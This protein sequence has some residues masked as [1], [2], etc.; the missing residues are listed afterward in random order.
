MSEPWVLCI[1]VP[2]AVPAQSTAVRPGLHGGFSARGR[3][4]MVPD[5]GRGWCT[6]ATVTAPSAVVDWCSSAAGGGRGCCTVF[7]VPASVT[8]F[9]FQGERK[10]DVEGVCQEGSREWAR[11]KW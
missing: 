5:R 8:A 3:G 9:F 6:A 4:R 10:R 1:A 7:A 11:R 2:W